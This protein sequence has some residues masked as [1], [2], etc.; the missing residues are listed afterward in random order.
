MRRL[1]TLIRLLIGLNAV[2]GLGIAVL[3]WSMWPGIGRSIGSL[4][5]VLQRVRP[6]VVT[7]R[8]TGEK[9]VPIELGARSA[10]AS[11]HAIDAPIK[12]VV[13]AGGS[14]VIIDARQGYILTNNH[15]VEYATSIDVGIADGRHFTATLI[16]R[17]P[18]TDLALLKIEPKDLPSIRIGNSDKARVGDLVVAVGSPFGLEGTAT[19]GIISAAMRTEIGHEAFEDYFQIDAQINRGNSGGALVNAKGELI[20]INTVIAGGRGQGYT[21]GFAIPINMAIT[22]QDEIKKHGRMQRGFTGLTVKDYTHSSDGGATDIHFGAVVEQVATETSAAAQGIK[23]G[24]IIVE[25]AR[26]PVRTAA[27]FLTRA[28]MVPLGAQLPIVIISEGKRRRISLHV[29]ANGI[30]PERQAL[31]S[32]LGAIGGLVVGEIVPGSPHYGT[33][34][35]AL[36]LDVPAA[37]ASQA[38][39]LAP[40]DVIIAVDGT[41]VASVDDL[42]RRIEQA[43]LEFKLD[44]MR[45]AVPAWVRMKR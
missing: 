20:G 35:G 40:G 32:H 37:S 9:S 44:I 28:S 21:I 8:V 7:L 23:P 3:L 2:V 12:E 4:P 41:R 27:E 39:G 33:L 30:E 36:I 34:R 16:G 17:D 10:G 25:A 6:A 26:K 11:A 18:G 43:G 13:K 38:A 42:T 1:R 22:I 31:R 29:I 5:T 24:D 14:G 15:V 19:A 45:S